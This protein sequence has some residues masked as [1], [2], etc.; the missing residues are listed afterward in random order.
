MC[1]DDGEQVVSLEKLTTSTIAEV[2]G[3]RKRGREGGRKRGREGGREGERERE[4][5]KGGTP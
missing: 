5:G 2:G 4:G 1:P 3:G